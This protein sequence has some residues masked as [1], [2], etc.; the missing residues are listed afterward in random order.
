MGMGAEAG[1]GGAGGGVWA[2]A[3]P[4]VPK[5]RRAVQAIVLARRACLFKR[6]MFKRVS[7]TTG[8]VL[9]LPRSWPGIARGAGGLVNPCPMDGTVGSI[10]DV[11]AGS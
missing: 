7:F 11:A 3:R 8:P 2:S 1:A 4:G 10:N 5:A 9:A 6:R